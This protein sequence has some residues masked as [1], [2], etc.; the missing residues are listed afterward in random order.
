MEHPLLQAHHFFALMVLLSANPRPAHL[1]VR[2]NLCFLF[3]TC[4]GN[5][6]RQD[7]GRSDDN[8]GYNAPPARVVDGTWIESEGG[9]SEG[10]LYHFAHNGNGIDW[11][12]ADKLVISFD[13]FLYTVLVFS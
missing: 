7:S 4:K 13:Q 9:G 10:F 8:D 11:S 1:Q 2:L 5:N 3:N 6:D 12:D